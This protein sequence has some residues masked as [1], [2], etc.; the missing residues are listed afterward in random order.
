LLNNYSKQKIFFSFF[1]ILLEIQVVIIRDKKRRR[2]KELV[3]LLSIYSYSRIIKQKSHYLFHECIVYIYITLNVFSIIFFSR[4]KTIQF[5]S[6]FVISANVIVIRDFIRWFVCITFSRIDRLWSFRLFS[7]ILDLLS[8]STIEG[9]IR[10]CFFRKS[11]WA[12]E[13]IQNWDESITEYWWNPFFCGGGWI[14]EKWEKYDEKEKKKRINPFI[15]RYYF[16]DVL[17]EKKLF[18]YLLR[19]SWES[20]LNIDIVD[21]SFLEF[22]M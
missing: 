13:N 11:L 19:K 21:E 20:K 2:R 14:L 5:K 17:T 1:F 10:L 18:K 12:Y 22:E 16:V 9:S 7:F 4:L 8:C 15:V 3:L 6:N